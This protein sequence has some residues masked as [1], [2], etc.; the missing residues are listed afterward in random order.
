MHTGLDFAAPTGTPVYAAADGVVE[1]VRFERGY[2]HVVRLRHQ[3]GM[4]TLYA[5]LSRFAPGLRA[6]M[7]VRQ[8]QTIG[9]VGSTGM[10]TGPH[11]H[12]EVHIAGR[13]VNPATASPPP[14]PALAGRAAAE[15]HA[16]RRALSAQIAL[17]A[18]GREEIAL[19][20]E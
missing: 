20:G 7:R 5:H 17:L 10:S 6:G 12:Y 18:R 11:L 19:A 13:A 16:A 2:G 1:S 15:F 14:P 3:G 8:G 9:R 4:R